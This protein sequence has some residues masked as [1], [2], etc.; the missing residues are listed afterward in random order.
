MRA[1]PT[2]ATVAEGLTVP[3]RILLAAGAARRR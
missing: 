3:E 2:A 1:S